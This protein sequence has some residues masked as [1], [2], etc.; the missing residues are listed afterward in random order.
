MRANATSPLPIN[1]TG[2]AYITNVN[3]VTLLISTT[4]LPRV[5]KMIEAMKDLK[6]FLVQALRA[7]SRGSRKP[8]MSRTVEFISC[9]HY[10]RCRH[11]KSHCPNLFKG[12]GIIDQRRSSSNTLKV[13]EVNVLE[14]QKSRTKV[15]HL[16]VMMTKRDKPLQDFD[17]RIRLIE[18]DQRKKLENVLK[19]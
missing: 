7:T 19:G 1:M 3:P 8:P 5:T 2:P 17:S 4:D 10:K 18:R 12:K 6:L 11:Y 15:D 14:F 13:I 16:E 9:H